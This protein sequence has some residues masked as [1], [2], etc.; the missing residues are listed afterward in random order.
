M[1][2]TGFAHLRTLADYS[3]SV[4][5]VALSADGR[6]VVSASRDKTVKVW[7]L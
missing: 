6:R 2:P 5:V 7:D 1:R 4:M 3:A